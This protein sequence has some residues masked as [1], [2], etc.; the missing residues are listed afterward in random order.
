VAAYARAG[1]LAHANNV[2]YMLASD[3]V[4]AESDLTEVPVWLDECEAFAGRMQ[5]SHELAHIR[6]VRA[7]YERIQGRLPEA[8]RLLDEVIGVFRVAGDI[9]CLVRSL[10]ELARF[11]LSGRPD[12]ATTILLDALT[13]AVLGGD[14]SL[15][16]RVLT[17]LAVTADAAGDVP[18]AGRAL[19]AL[20]SLPAERSRSGPRVPAVP[21]DLRS[22]LFEPPA[23]IYAEEGRAGGPSLL[24]AMY[25]SAAETGP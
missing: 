16:S 12:T 10:L 2:R 7:E 4:D 8:R 1:D 24:L 21:P 22:R 18:L 20:D 14:T 25:E 3:A 17:V 23:E 6:R 5:F 9:R 13:A 15:Q 19:G 11:H